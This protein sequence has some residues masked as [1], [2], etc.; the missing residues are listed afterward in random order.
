MII[1]QKDIIA[2]LNVELAEVES[3]IAVAR[4]EQSAARKVEKKLKACRVSHKTMHK[5]MGLQELYM[6]TVRG[7]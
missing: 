3:K 7:Q 2:L 1:D 4:A 6:Q 5:Y